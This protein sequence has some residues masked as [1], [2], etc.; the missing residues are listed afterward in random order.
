MFLSF[1]ASCAEGGEACEVT[2][3]WEGKRFNPLE[4][5]DELAVKIASAKTETAGY[6]Y[7]NTSNLISISF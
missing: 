6:S 3:R 2:M 4:E 5:G 7:E 1:D